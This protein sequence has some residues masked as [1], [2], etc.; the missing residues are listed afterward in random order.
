MSPINVTVGEAPINVSAS[1]T[2]VEVEIVGGQG[3]SGTVSVGT[4]TTGAPGSS[5]TVTNVGSSTA[6]VLNFVI[7]AGAAGA[8]G[9][10]GAQGPAGPQGPQGP[11]G[12]TGATG[13]AGATGSAGPTGPQGPKGDT[14]NTGP[15]GPAGASGATG[16]QGPAGVVAATAPLTY[17]APTQ[18]VAISV[19]TTAGT[20]AS[21]DHTHT[22]LH[23]RSHAIT[24]TSDHTATNWRLFHSNG[25]GQVV[26]LAFGNS[27]QALISNGASAAPSWGQAGSTSASDLTSGTLADARLSANARQA[28]DNLFHPFLLAGM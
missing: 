17:D 2:E 3:P 7:P 9:P 1:G 23:D 14:G 13:P 24:S 4:V 8:T 5:A 20:V 10:A 25:S 18:T 28:I 26:E 22:Q 6:A 27:G 16:P 11:A 12:A 21:G 15:T 19:G